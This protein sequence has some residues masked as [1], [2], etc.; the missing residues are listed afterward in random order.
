L[1]G[2]VNSNISK[3]TDYIVVGADPGTNYQKAVQLNVKVLDEEQLLKLFVQ[4]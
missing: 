2:R 1:G 4:R 3:K